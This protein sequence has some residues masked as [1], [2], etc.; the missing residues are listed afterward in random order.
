MGLLSPKDLITGPDHAQTYYAATAVRRP[1]RPPLRGEHHCDICVVGA[2]FSGISTALHLAERGYKV[3]VVEAVKVGYG[4]SGRNGGQI[5][6][7]YSRDDGVIRAR[8]GTDTADALLAM[9]H[10]GGDIIRAR[11]RDY[12]IDCDLKRGGF[13]A[14]FNEK[15]MDFLK[16]RMEIWSRAGNNA[17]HI[18]PKDKMP[19]VAASDLYIGGLLDLRGGHMHPLNLVEGEAMALERLG[20]TIFEH[21]RVMHVEAGRKPVVH[22]EHGSV[23]AKNVVVCG[24]AY[25]GGVLPKLTSRIMAVSSQ[26]VTTEVLG[27]SVTDR[28]MPED[29]CLEDCNFLLDYY[30]I[31]GDKRLLF[32]GGVVYSGADP[33]DIRKRLYPH[34]VKTFP[35]LEGV[36][37]DF[38]WSGHFA[39]TLTRLPHIG[40]LSDTVYF[41]QGDSGH[42][43]TTCHLLGRLVAEAV[44]GQQ[45][46]FD[47][48]ANMRNYPFP[49]GRMFRVPLTA[50]GAWYYGLR[51]K[52]GV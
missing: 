51:E 6:N 41:I 17:L 29:Y 31:T 40:R 33:A 50:L 38:A 23:F 30:R 8:Y 12:A 15:Q 35:Q 13:F 1:P 39:L 9:S 2:G 27:P 47:V 18:V 11:V 49:G 26:V 36:R 48:F 5:V 19:H 46:R 42:G 24:N 32:G 3:M 34:I 52:L 37:L 43:V 45:E 14:A 25:L 16:R 22:T 21:S 20:G 4:A 7:G 44:A 10:E 28:L